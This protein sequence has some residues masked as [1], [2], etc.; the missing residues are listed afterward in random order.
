[1]RRASGR[2]SHGAKYTMYMYCIVQWSVQPQPQVRNTEYRVGTDR[3]YRDRLRRARS[4]H[5][6]SAARCYLHYTARDRSFIRLY[7][8]TFSNYSYSYLH[9]NLILRACLRYLGW[10][11]YSYFLSYF[12]SDLL[13]STYYFNRQLV[14]KFFSYAITKR[15]KKISTPRVGTTLFFKITTCRQKFNINIKLKELKSEHKKYNGSKQCYHPSLHK[16]K[17]KYGC[18]TTPLALSIYIYQWNQ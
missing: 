13:T 17:T 6:R 3:D 11:R 7:F 5:L 1:M 14:L 2:T 8:W 12:N 4:L 15:N 18:S 9:F 16:T 10:F